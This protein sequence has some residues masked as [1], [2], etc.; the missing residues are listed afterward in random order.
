MSSS[1]DAMRRIICIVW[2]PHFTRFLKAIGSAPSAPTISKRFSYHLGIVIITK[3]THFLLIWAIINSLPNSTEKQTVIGGNSRKFLQFP[4]RNFPPLQILTWPFPLILCF[5]FLPFYYVLYILVWSILSWF[6]LLTSSLHS[7][8]IPIGSCRHEC[9]V[10]VGNR[11]ACG[12][13]VE[14]AFSG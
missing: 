8:E 4:P 11:C 7:S 12:E 1:Q 3:F 10:A 13:V 6:S 14:D 2:S 5:P 9:D